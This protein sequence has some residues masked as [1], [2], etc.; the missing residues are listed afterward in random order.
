[1]S[2]GKNAGTIDSIV[3]IITE[4]GAP[5]Q[6]ERALQTIKPVATT[7]AAVSNTS[8]ADRMTV[9]IL[10]CTSRKVLAEAVTAPEVFQIYNDCHLYV[11]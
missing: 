11:F 7:C 5:A 8:K 3:S 6:S 10:M 9:C 2:P 1:M 4:Q